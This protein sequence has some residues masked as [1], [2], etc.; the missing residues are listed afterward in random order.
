MNLLEAKELFN[1]IVDDC[2]TLEGVHFM[3]AP[4]IATHSVVD[5]YEIHMSGKKFDDKTIT[6]LRDL[7]ITNGLFI[8]TKETAVG[9]YRIKKGALV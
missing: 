8:D 2:P 3:I 1:E 9:M 6:Y 5:G 7:A 4:S